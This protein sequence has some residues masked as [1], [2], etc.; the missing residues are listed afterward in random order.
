MCSNIECRALTAGPA[1]DTDKSVSIGEAAHIYGARAGSARFRAD[2]TD[3]SRA[4]VTNGIWLCTNCH[5]LIDSDTTRYPADLLFEWRSQHDEFVVSRLGSANDKLRLS[6]EKD[7]LEQFS[8]DSA[9]ARRIVIDRPL[10][11]EYKLSSE[12]LRNYLRPIHRRWGDLQRNLYTKP[13]AVIDAVAFIPWLRSKTDESSRLIEILTA[14]YTKELVAAW[15]PMGTPGNP[16][17]IKHA[18]GLIRS[19]AENIIQW[20]ESVRFVSVHEQHQRL[21]ACIP[22]F[23]GIQLNQLE[24]ATRSLD[25]VSDW[26]DANAASDTRKHFDHLIV[27]KTPD[28]WSER[29]QHEIARLKRG[30]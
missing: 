14:L 7:Y 29:I 15:G 2:M 8:H 22:G 20:E 11:W 19:A 6:L 10:G 23:L 3:A 5:K 28:G 25:E 18:C 13:H 9:F 16:T 24:L 17:E 21:L 27:F 30:A 12:L 4:D 26:I 1:V